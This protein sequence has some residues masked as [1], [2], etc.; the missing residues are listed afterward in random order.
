VYPSNVLCP[1]KY[2]AQQIAFPAAYQNYLRAGCMSSD[3]LRVV[4]RQYVHRSRQ[5]VKKPKVIRCRIRKYQKLDGSHPKKEDSTDQ[6]L[7]RSIDIK[8]LGGKNV[9]LIGSPNF[10]HQRRIVGGAPYLMVE[11][12][13]LGL[14]LVCHFRQLG[15]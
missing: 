10:F 13:K 1:R 8:I 5:A 3:K 7:T 11:N 9:T 4:S 2:H 6:E 12:Q 15:R 14:G